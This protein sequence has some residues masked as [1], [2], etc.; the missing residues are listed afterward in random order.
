MSRLPADSNHYKRIALA[1]LVAPLMLL[2]I[3]VIS[4][5][6]TNIYGQ[7]AFDS[8]SRF[9]RIYS[10]SD[11]VVMAYVVAIAALVTLV[12]GVPVY[13][14]LKR[15]GLANIYTLSAAGFIVLLPLGGIYFSVSGAFVAACFWLVVA[16]YTAVT[17]KRLRYT[18]SVITLTA[19]FLVLLVYII[20]SN[21]SRQIVEF[22]TDRTLERN[23]P[24]PDW[25]ASVAQKH[26]I[27]DISDARRLR[28]QVDLDLPVSA[29]SRQQAREFFKAGYIALRRPGIAADFAMELVVMM[30]VPGTDYAHIF[31]LQQY[32][33][34]I[35]PTELATRLLLLQHM[36]TTNQAG[37]EAYGY[38]QSLSYDLIT[39]SSGRASVTQLA[40]VCRLLANAYD[41]RQVNYFEISVFKKCV[42]RL[43]HYQE[44]PE[45]KQPLMEIESQLEWMQRVLQSQQ[46][47]AGAV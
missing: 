27:N 9:V 11:V 37:S 41:G 42:A 38:A 1:V 44:S 28:A 2:S 24:V 14:V 26:D 16:P 31:K 29:Q 47:A 8:Y 17:R 34:S 33:L 7:F 5:I 46:Q 30:D 23:V 43:R 6:V 32:A 15:F 22:R 19:V 3:A 18:A 13:L 35:Y 21:F 10:S 36:L 39:E 45:V 12:Y 25:W 40:S 20:E 4:T